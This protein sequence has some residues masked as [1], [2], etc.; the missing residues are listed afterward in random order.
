MYPFTIHI[1]AFSIG[2]Y[3]L[4][5]SLA[6]LWATIGTY[7][8]LCSTH[9][10]RPC[11]ILVL[12]LGV[13]LVGGRGM[14][15]LSEQALSADAFLEFSWHQF[16]MVG[17]LLGVLMGGSIL[18]LRKK[19]TLWVFADAMLLPLAGTVVLAK[20]GCYLHGCCFG[21][22]TTL[23]WAVAFPVLSPAHVHA[24][25]NGALFSLP[26]VHPT[27]LYEIGGV[28]ILTLLILSFQK[29]LPAG[30]RLLLFTM[31]FTA[32]R[33]GNDFFRVYSSEA[34]SFLPVYWTIYVLC[35]L[36]AGARFVRRYA[37]KK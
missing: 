12:L 37:L 16:S 4:F 3:G 36:F 32:I 15:L 10:K 8:A 33:M 13:A 27:Q 26:R 21:K 2:E 7:S 5:M 14:A 18:L 34:A 23:P 1:G 28:L 20:I 19:N 22:V 35:F 31:G 11:V 9:T 6:L 17:A 25:N 30:G 24:L 29:K